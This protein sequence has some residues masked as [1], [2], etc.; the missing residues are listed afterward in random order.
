MTRILVIDKKMDKDYN[1]IY[2]ESG[3]DQRDAHP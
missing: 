2:G 3:K 1:K